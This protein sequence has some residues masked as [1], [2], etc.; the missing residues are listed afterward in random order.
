MKSNKRKYKILILLLC[1]FIPFVSFYLY[2]RLPVGPGVNAHSL[3]IEAFQKTW[4]NRAVL[5]VGMGD[6]IVTGFGSGKSEFAFYKMLLNNPDDEYPEMKG[7]TLRK[8]FPEL[9]HINIAMNSTTSGDHIDQVEAIPMQSKDV[10]G[11]VLLST[12][13]IDLIHNYGRTPPQDQA[14]YGATKEQIPLLAAK[15]ERRLDKL[16]NR[17]EEKFPGGLRI[18][19]FS[20]YDPTDGVGDIENA[21]PFL[22][23]IKALPKW[24]DGLFALESWNKIIKRKAEERRTV[25]LVD[26]HA[27]FLGHGLHC[28]DK[29]NPHYHPDSPYYWYFDNLEDPNKYGYDAIRKN[30]LGIMTR[31]FS[32]GL[33]KY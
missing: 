28:R 2:Y 1:V 26:N 20:I 4:S 27:L 29:S 22:K 6:S 31:E 7:K 11:I 14:S 21:H 16:L 3:P 23:L 30:I 9:R 10:F 8:V 15:F 12:G 17:I 19:L 32:N 18:L 33:P 13:G 25:I 5:L 24:P